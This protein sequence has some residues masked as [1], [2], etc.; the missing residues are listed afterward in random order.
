M[1]GNTH[2]RQSMY[3]NQLDKLSDSSSNKGEKT[4]VLFNKETNSF[5]AF[6]PP[7]GFLWRL[8]RTVGIISS[9]ERILLKSTHET[10]ST[11]NKTNSSVLP[12][13]N[14]RISDI[15]RVMTGKPREHF[16]AVT[17]VCSYTKN[18]NNELIKKGRIKKK[19]TIDAESANTASGRFDILADKTF[20]RTP[21]ARLSRDHAGSAHRL[22]GDAIGLA[23]DTMVPIEDQTT[24][25]KKAFSGNFVSL[26]DNG[27][28]TI[29][30][31]KPLPG[32]IKSDTRGQFWMANFENN[33]VSVVDL[34]YKYDN[35]DDAYYP[36]SLGKK[37]S[38]SSN[39]K[40]INVTLIEET[41][42][43]DSRDGLHVLSYEVETGGE[44]KI[45]KRI[46]VDIWPERGILPE[47]GMLTLVELM[48]EYINTGDISA[49][50]CTAGIGRTGTIITADQIYRTYKDK[51]MTTKEADE[52]LEEM[53][54]RGRDQ[55]SPS[56]V[57]TEEQYEALRVFFHQVADIIPE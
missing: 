40:N 1:P 37:L 44:T 2:L 19:V 25:Y 42:L 13:R 53:V 55:R 23:I 43:E 17:H 33:S 48:G 6:T 35:N 45:I 18:E 30:T 50:H 15:R 47:G 57:E 3:V 36:E 21:V 34:T 24:D 49:V 29:A 54:L 11:F 39:G 38:Y 52:N 5:E 41:A 46:K 26:V 12:I 8:G 32:R 22:S 51:K 4:K 31:Q 27:Q 28:I 9:K 7:K 56:F 16:P 10:I 20:N 14:I